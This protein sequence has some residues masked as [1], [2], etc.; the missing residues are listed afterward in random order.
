MTRLYDPALVSIMRLV[1]VWV[2]AAEFAEREEHAAEVCWIW[3]G[4]ITSA[5]YGNVKRGG[6][7]FKAHRLLWTILRG[8]LRA[9]LVLDHLCRNRRCVNPYHLEP[10]TVREN[11]LRGDGPSA[12]AYRAARGLEASL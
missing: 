8:K 11:T 12:R 1:D 5:G 4:A 9:R 6:R 10:V 7:N 3:S 2:C